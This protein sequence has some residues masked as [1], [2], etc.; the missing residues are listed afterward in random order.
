MDNRELQRIYARYARA[1]AREI[2]AASRSRRRVDH[3]LLESLRARRREIERG[4]S[5]QP[6]QRP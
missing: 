1:I 3:D 2:E 5:A 4:L 6:D